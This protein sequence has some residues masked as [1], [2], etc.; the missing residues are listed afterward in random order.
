MTTTEKTPIPGAPGVTLDP[1]QTRRAMCLVLAVSL[2]A[3]R[4]VAWSNM[5]AIAQWLDTGKA[6]AS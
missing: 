6:A 1:G 5:V 4:G 2:F 3:G